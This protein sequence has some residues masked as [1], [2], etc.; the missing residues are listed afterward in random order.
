[1]EH[2]IDINCVE[3]SVL[4]EGLIHQVYG[5]SLLENSELET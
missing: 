2:T 4:C 1:M 3:L 5:S